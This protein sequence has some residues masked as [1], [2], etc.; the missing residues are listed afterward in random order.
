MTQLAAIKKEN[1]IPEDNAVVEDAFQAY[2]DASA[3]SSLIIIDRSRQDFNNNDI[4]SHTITIDPDFVKTSWCQNIKDKYDVV[5]QNESPVDSTTINDANYLRAINILDIFQHKNVLDK[6]NMAAHVQ[7]LMTHTHP[8]I[9]IIATITLV[10]DI[11]HVDSK[12]YSDNTSSKVQF[13]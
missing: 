8:V 3:S 9:F 13:N 12:F 11:Y 1:G 2:L 6:I 10:D 4:E 5:M 7:F